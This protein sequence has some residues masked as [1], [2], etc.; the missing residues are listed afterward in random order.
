M[1]KFRGNISRSSRFNSNQ[2]YSSRDN[3]NQRS[4]Q[5]K[6]DLS[7]LDSNLA[8][9]EEEKRF[10]ACE[11]LGDLCEFNA[12][13]TVAL[14]RIL[15]ARILNKFIMRLVDSSLRVREIAF[16]SLQ[17][18]SSLDLEM[19]SSKLISS[20]IFRTA[21]TAS[22]EQEQLPTSITLGSIEIKKNA[23]YIVVNILCTIPTAI[24]ELQSIAPTFFT[25][26]LLFT[27]STTT[28]FS[29]LNTT[30]NAV[31]LLIKNIVHDSHFINNILGA[32]Y[33][34][35]IQ[36]LLQYFLQNKS[37]TSTDSIPSM[38]HD[39]WIMIIQCIE[40]LTYFA[41]NPITNLTLLTDVNF[42]LMLTAIFRI[43]IG[44]S[45]GM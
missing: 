6:V 23:L 35:A 41:L 39:Q 22:I 19:L 8:S 11:L 16:R 43:L 33:I 1:G 10:N 36:Q 26:H 20:G 24:T 9:F 15:S 32:N 3:P 13:K 7:V 40:G 2:P 38:E 27:L 17:R 45:Q 18:I 28:E 44:S 4:R 31:T 42:A 21:V 34:N 25:E 14:E 12:H 30:L 5:E 29:L 37:L